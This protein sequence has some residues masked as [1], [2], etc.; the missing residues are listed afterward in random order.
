MAMKKIMS[1]FLIT[2]ISIALFAGEK[3]DN[4]RQSK[5]S[6]SS[7]R[8]SSEAINIVP[9]SDR[10]KSNRL[11]SNRKEKNKNSPASIS[12]S[13]SSPDHIFPYL[14]SVRRT[15]GHGYPPRD[16]H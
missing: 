4:L 5:G 1:I 9:P 14:G 8:A 13:N 15:G 10:K 16:M 7:L 3:P 6:E 2:N 12:S 11:S